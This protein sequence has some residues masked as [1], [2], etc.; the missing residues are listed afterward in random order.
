MKMEESKYYLTQE[1]ASRFCQGLCNQYEFTSEGW[2]AKSRELIESLI[3][4]FTD[5]DPVV[6]D[7]MIHMY[8]VA[9]EDARLGRGDA[10]LENSHRDW[11]RQQA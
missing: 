7:E 9:L 5:Y 4:Y 6:A 1:L 2:R 3:E 8:A 10:E 11:Q